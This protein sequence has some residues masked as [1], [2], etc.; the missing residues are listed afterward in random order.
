[1][2]NP[3]Y[4]ATL[5]DVVGNAFDYIICG[6]GAAGLTLAAR[7]S[8][9]PQVSVLVLDAG[10]ANLDDPAILVPAQY[11]RQVFDERYDWS[12]TTVPQKHCNNKSFMWARGKSLGGS[13]AMNFFVYS[14]PA[15]EDIDAWEELGNPGWNWSNHLKYMKRS[16]KFTPPSPIQTEVFRQTYEPEYHGDKGELQVGFPILITDYEV[17]FQEAFNSLGVPTAK[18]PLGGNNYGTGMAAN[19]IDPTT[20]TRSYAVTAYYLPNKERTNLK[21]LLG[22]HVNKLVFKSPVKDDLLTAEGVEFSC[23]GGVHVVQAN[24]EVILS[25]GGIKSP[26]ILELSGIGD[27]AV[28]TPLG[29]DCVVPLPGVGNGV[30]EHVICPVSFELHHKDGGYNTL[31]ILR[32]PA[33]AEAEMKRFEKQEGIHTLGL[34]NFTFASLQQTSHAAQDLIDAVSLKL[35]RDHTEG[36][37]SDALWDQYKIQLRVLRS[38]KSV[39]LEWMILPTIGTRG[40]VPEDGKAYL[41]IVIGLNHPFSRGSIHIAST[42]PQQQPLCDPHYLENDFD[43]QLLVEGFKFARKL[44]ETEALKSIIAGEIDPGSEAQTEEQIRAHIIDEL[45]TTFHTCGACSMLPREKGGVV[46]PALKVYGTTNVRVVDLSI[47]PLHIAAHTQATVY[48][49]AEQAADLI[50]GKI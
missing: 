49:I 12:F 48:G 4:F 20:K 37:I 1:M 50:L 16:E 29:I 33:V 32:N 42:D 11:Y 5:G 24:R 17:P 10:R 14:R 40:T 15:A 22:A 19:T 35:D 21:V 8:E 47:V 9:D 26:Q 34:S 30:Q 2:S 25:A 6:G 23:E 38:E 46:D 41:T 36:R 28:L 7:L 45:S 27:P 39:D 31:D 44:T 13:S 43:M 3:T 18:E